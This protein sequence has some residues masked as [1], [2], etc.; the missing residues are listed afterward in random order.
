MEQWRWLPRAMGRANRVNHRTTQQDV[1][2][3]VDEVLA[4]GDEVIVM[5]GPCSVE[6][7]AQILECLRSIGKQTKD[8]EFNC[9]GCHS[10][11]MPQAN[12]SLKDGDVYARLLGREEGILVGISSGAALY[13]A[14]QVAAREENRGKLIVTIIPSFGER[15]LNTDLMAPYRYEGS[16]EV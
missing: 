13:A 10:D 5:A 3:I 2:Q 8:D 16:D 12:L 1:K 7:E 9:G 14:L 15:Y 6:S 4:V 11:P